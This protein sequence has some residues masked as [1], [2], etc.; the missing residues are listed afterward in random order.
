MPVEAM[1][2]EP[3]E[4]CKLRP[5]FDNLDLAD[6][7]ALIANCHALDAEHYRRLESKHKALAEWVKGTN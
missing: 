4:L 1:Q 6:Q 5:E 7:M 2:P 3:R